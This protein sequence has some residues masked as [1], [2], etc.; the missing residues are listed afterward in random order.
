MRTR[1]VLRCWNRLRSS[2]N[3]SSCNGLPGVI[4]RGKS[5]RACSG[6]HWCFRSWSLQ[7][8]LQAVQLLKLLLVR[9][10]VHSL[11]APAG[12]LLFQRITPLAG[13]RTSG[14][15]FAKPDAAAALPLVTRVP[16]K[17]TRQDYRRLNS[18]RVSHSAVTMRL[19]AADA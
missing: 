7:L 5:P 15:L 2:R 3:D 8:A 14:K 1:R 18:A 9:A 12:D 10:V 16:R 11:R 13:R 19:W 4:I 17:P 6:T